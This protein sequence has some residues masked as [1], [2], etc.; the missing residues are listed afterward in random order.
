MLV[1]ATAALLVALVGLS[2]L[3]SGVH[4]PSDVLVGYAAALAWVVS[5]ALADRVLQS[6]HRR[7]GKPAPGLTEVSDA[8]GKRV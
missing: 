6:R 2:R 7:R 4:Y 1:W 3:Y 8:G 5:V